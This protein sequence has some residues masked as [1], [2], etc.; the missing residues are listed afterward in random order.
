MGRS[1]FALAAFLTASGAW[2]EET[3]APKAA[4]K[5]HPS[6]FLSH[7]DSSGIMEDFFGTRV[8]R[9]APEAP[10]GANKRD[11]AIRWNDPA[12]AR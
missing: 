11:P 9:T 10:G 12:T 8:E 3:P 2:A 5:D 4:D 7:G 1:V 6:G